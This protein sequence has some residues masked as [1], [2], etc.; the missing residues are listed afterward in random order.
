M[1]RNAIHENSL[2][3]ASCTYV[4]CVIISVRCP[5]CRLTYKPE[6]GARD[7]NI[8]EQCWK[9]QTKEKR[10]G[11]QRKKK[12][13]LCN[14]RNIFLLGGS[15]VDV[16]VQVNWQSVG[17]NVG[18]TCLMKDEVQESVICYVLEMC[19]ELQ[20]LYSHSSA[21]Q[22]DLTWCTAVEYKFFAVL[23]SFILK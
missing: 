16:W 5:I 21:L 3:L 14:K 7:G 12:E 4:F 19:W 11:E 22:R 10:V 17:R 9:C 2:C 8:V 18:K 6:E 23:Y 15:L 1:G 13:L 20:H